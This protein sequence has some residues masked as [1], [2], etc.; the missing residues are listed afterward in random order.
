[1]IKLFRFLF[2]R[3]P[4]FTYRSVFIEQKEKW[5]IVRFRNGQFNG[6]VAFCDETE[7]NSLVADL[8][9]GRWDDE[10]H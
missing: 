9:Q 4:K 6:I 2:K 5:G 7:I 3:K 1:M 8:K 10:Y